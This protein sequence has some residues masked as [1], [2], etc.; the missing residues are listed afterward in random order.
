MNW[1]IRARMAERTDVQKHGGTAFLCFQR[2][3]LGDVV[4]DDAKIAGSAQRRYKSALLQHGSLLLVR[5]E[6]AP[7]LPGVCD[8]VGRPLSTSELISSWR[9]EFERRTG[10]N[11]ESAEFSS[12]DRK[13]IDDITLQKFGCVN[14]TRRR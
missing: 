11:L 5:S 14:W 12:T 3:S 2:R 1:N 8:L 7:E 13:A 4:L 10:W 9:R 6:S